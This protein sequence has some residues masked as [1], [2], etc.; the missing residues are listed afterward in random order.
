MPLKIYS[1]LGNRKGP[2]FGVMSE[3]DSS[4][5]ECGCCDVVS[6]AHDELSVGNR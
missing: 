1:P 4:D 2:T 6:A 3:H 5:L